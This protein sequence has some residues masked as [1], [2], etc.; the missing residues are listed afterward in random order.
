MTKSRFPVLEHAFR[1][2][3]ED[4]ISFVATARVILHNLFVTRGNMVE[5]NSDWDVVRHLQRH[6]KNV[7]SHA[8]PGNC[9]RDALL[10]YVTKQDEQVSTANY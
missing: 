8:H 4:D 7:T 2:T 6:S 10:A 5:E 9:Q 1:L 3:H